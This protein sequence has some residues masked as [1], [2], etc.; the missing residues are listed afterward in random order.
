MTKGEGINMGQ[1]KNEKI[2][3]DVV[4]VHTISRDD[5]SIDAINTIVKDQL[6]QMQGPENQQIL[7]MCYHDVLPYTCQPTS[8][9]SSPDQSAS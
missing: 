3:R 6:N 9:D 4:H 7:T 8:E 1:Q 5:E 2:G